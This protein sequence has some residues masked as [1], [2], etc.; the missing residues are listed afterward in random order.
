[1]LE[2]AELSIEQVERLADSALVSKEYSEFEELAQIIASLKKHWSPERL[3]K[4]LQRLARNTLLVLNE[5]GI[6]LA[7]LDKNLS[8]ETAKGRGAKLENLS[9]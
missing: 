6:E 8:E 4:D 3:P 5:F 9:P 1:M 2:H 7:A